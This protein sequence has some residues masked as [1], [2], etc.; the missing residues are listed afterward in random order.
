[1]KSCVFWQVGFES[2]EQKFSLR[3]VKSKKI[4]NNNDRLVIIVFLHR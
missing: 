1:M 2:D 3:R 4:S